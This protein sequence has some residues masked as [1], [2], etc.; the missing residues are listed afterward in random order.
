MNHLRFLIGGLCLWLALAWPAAAQTPDRTL[1]GDAVCTGC[2]DQSDNKPVLSIYRTAHGV[3]ADGR[4]PGC[5][6]CHGSSTAH[7]KNEAK[8][9]PRPAVD[10]SFGA[11]DIAP[12]AQQ[13]QA[14]LGCH[15]NSQRAHW[16]GSQHQGAD[17]TCSNCHT[18]H[19]KH[20][21]VLAKETQPE[22]CFA[23]H[24]SERA[25]IHRISTH[26]LAAGKM[27]CTDC[28]NPHGSLGPNLM[29]KASVNETCFT[30]H[31]DKRGPF[32]W[33]HEPVTESCTNCHTPHGSN[34]APLLKA[35][36]PW[37]CQSCHTGDHA[38]QLNSAA[39]MQRGGVTTANGALPLAS[40][41]AR[42]QLGGRNCQACHFQTH[43]S[44]HPA[45]AKLTR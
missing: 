25:Q 44:N 38:S 34:N 36:T 16:A 1:T 21:R 40:A 39:N 28:H 27:G 5:Q 32:L 22:V 14:C 42:A 30:C 17:V 3:K 37:L 35:R 8:T 41:A 12:I 18:S 15:T 23:C 4:T 31:A 26:P 2:H 45:G 19:T 33:E 20:D 13:T 43:G 9:D 11:K 29:R 7:V 6:S 24:K 10:I